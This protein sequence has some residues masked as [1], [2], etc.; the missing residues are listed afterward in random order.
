MQI[1]RDLMQREVLTLPA[2]M[3]FTEAMHLIGVAGVHGAPV[4]DDKG[5]V[6]GVLSAMDLLRATEQAYDD[7]RDDG[8]GSDPLAQLRSSTAQRL[9]NPDPTWVSPDASIAE[10]A[11][12][13]RETGCHRV[14]VGADGRLEGIV[15]AFDLLGAVSNA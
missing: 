14:L 2:A 3:P 12:V 15:T 7:E 11:R 6:I 5:A 1:V 8:E 4:L 9:A 13:M 10:V